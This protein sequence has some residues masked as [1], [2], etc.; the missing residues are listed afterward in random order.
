MSIYLAH[1]AIKRGLFNAITMGYGG[2]CWGGKHTHTDTHI[3]TITYP[4]CLFWCTYPSLKHTTLFTHAWFPL[5]RVWPLT[6][7]AAKTKSNQWRVPH[8][9]SAVL[10]L[11]SVVPSKPS[12]DLGDFL[13]VIIPEQDA[14]SP[15]FFHRHLTLFFWTK[16]YCAIVVLMDRKCRVD[17]W[18]ILRCLNFPPDAHERGFA[19]WKHHIWIQMSSHG[20]IDLCTHTHMHTPHTHIAHANIFTK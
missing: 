6:R 3:Q 17:V 4:P 16:K 8:Q 15:V 11:S 10:W 7:S 13:W 19:M 9:T 2:L 14:S 5:Y 12:K 20:Y 1:S 18:N